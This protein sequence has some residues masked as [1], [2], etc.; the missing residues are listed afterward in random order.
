MKTSPDQTA[1]LEQHLATGD[2]L[3]L[4]DERGDPLA[5][6][7]AH[8][9]LGDAMFSR[10]AANVVY[11]SRNSNCPEPM[12]PEWYLRQVQLGRLPVPTHLLLDALKRP[13]AEVEA[14]SM[15]YTAFGEAAFCERYP[16]LKPWSDLGMQRLHDECEGYRRQGYQA[17]DLEAAFNADP[18]PAVSWAEYLAGLRARQGLRPINTAGNQGA[19]VLVNPIEAG[20]TIQEAR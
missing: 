16:H 14:H 20:I 19:P 1:V 11:R 3:Y 8:P 12:F 4:L 9:E 5:A 7:E 2:P 15:A 17:P 18:D 13:R 10:I 6:S